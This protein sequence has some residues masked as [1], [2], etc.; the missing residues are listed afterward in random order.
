MLGRHLSLLLLRQA[1]LCERFDCHRLDIRSLP[2][3]L[4]H[5]LLCRLQQGALVDL[6]TDPNAEVNARPRSIV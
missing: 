4:A 5:P 3:V 6:F 1:L 2:E